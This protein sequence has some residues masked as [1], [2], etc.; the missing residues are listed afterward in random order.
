MVELLEDK[1]KT[2]ALHLDLGRFG[3]K[4]AT[5]ELVAHE[6][7]AEIYRVLSE[8]IEVLRVKYTAQLWPQ[9]GLRKQNVTVD[10]N[11]F[12]EGQPLKPSATHFPV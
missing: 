4:C 3:H 6:S 11:G 10:I 8:K 2:L 9:L 7:Y 12:Y 5:D 1:V